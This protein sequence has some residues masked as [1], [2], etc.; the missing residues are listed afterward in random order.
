MD[1]GKQSIKSSIKGGIQPKTFGNTGQNPNM[2]GQLGLEQKPKSRF[3]QPNMTNYAPIPASQKVSIKPV[4]MSQQSNKRNEDVNLATFLVPDGMTKEQYQQQS[5]VVSQ[6]FQIVDLYPVQI[7]DNDIKDEQ[8]TAASQEQEEVTPYQISV[9]HYRAPRQN[10]NIVLSI[11]DSDD[12]N[13]RKEVNYQETEI[14]KFGNAAVNMIYRQKLLYL[15][16]KSIKLEQQQGRV[17]PVALETLP[18]SQDNFKRISIKLC[19]Q[20]QAILQQIKENTSQ[21]DQVVKELSKYSVV[22]QVKQIVIDKSYNKIL[23]RLNVL[24]QIMNQNL[25]KIN[26]LIQLTE[27]QNEKVPAVSM[28]NMIDFIIKLPQQQSI[29]FSQLKY[30]SFYT[31]QIMCKQLEVQEEQCTSCSQFV[32]QFNQGVDAVQILYDFAKLKIPKLYNKLDISNNKLNLIVLPYLEFRQKNDFI[33]Q[34][35]QKYLIKMQEKKYFIMKTLMQEIMTKEEVEQLDQNYI[36]NQYATYRNQI[37]RNPNKFNYEILKKRPLFIL[38]QIK[39]LFHA[40]LQIEDL[41]YKIQNLQ[42]VYDTYVQ[43]PI[44]EQQLR[45]VQLNKMK[46][47]KQTLETDDQEVFRDKVVELKQDMDILFKFQN[48]FPS[49]VEGLPYGFIR[50]KDWID[51]EIGSGLTLLRILNS[52]LHSI[53]ILENQISE[54]EGLQL[55]EKSKKLISQILKLIDQEIPLQYYDSKLKLP[56]EIQNAV[57]EITN[58][59]LLDDETKQT[60]QKTPLQLP[61]ATPN[62]Q[63]NLQEQCSKVLER[64]SKARESILIKKQI[65]QEIST[66]YT[67]LNDY[68]FKYQIW[69]HINATRYLMTS[70]MFYD[71]ISTIISVEPQRFTLDGIIKKIRD[72][73]IYFEMNQNVQTSIYFKVHL[74]DG[75]QLLQ[76]FKDSQDEYS[77][78]LIANSKKPG[79][80][81]IDSLVNSLTNNVNNFLKI[82]TCTLTQQKDAILRA[83]PMYIGMIKEQFEDSSKAAELDQKFSEAETV[84]AETDTFFEKG[85]NKLGKIYELGVEAVGQEKTKKTM[86]LE[87]FRMSLGFDSQIQ[88]LKDKAEV[89]HNQFLMYKEKLS[90]NSLP[91]YKNKLEQKL[92]E[93]ESLNQTILMFDKT[94]TS[95]YYSSID[96]L[97]ALTELQQK[98]ENMLSL[99]NSSFIL[100]GLNKQLKQQQDTYGEVKKIQSGIKLHPSIEPIVLTTQ[101]IQAN[102]IEM[103]SNMIQ[104]ITAFVE[105]YDGFML[106]QDQINLLSEEFFQTVYRWLTFYEGKPS[107]RKLIYIEALAKIDVAIE[108]IGKFPILRVPCTKIYQTLKKVVETYQRDVNTEVMKMLSEFGQTYQTKGNKVQS[109]QEFQNELTYLLT[110]ENSKEATRKALQA[111]FEKNKKAEQPLS[112]MSQFVKATQTI[113][114]DERLKSMKR[115]KKLQNPDEIQTQMGG[116]QMDQWISS[117]KNMTN[118]LDMY[119]KNVNDNQLQPLVN[120]TQKIEDSAKGMSNQDLKKFIGRFL[121]MLKIDY[122]LSKFQ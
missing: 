3:V 33:L 31:C 117:C 4:D 7:K 99:A 34:D 53:D 2:S 52:K 11:K 42:N 6:N 83:M 111:F 29:E 84:L 60:P 64:L 58:K 49:E 91:I 112:R 22:S 119:F 30:A 97:D 113:S 79:S 101:E 61:L 76:L 78:L 46:I 68:C 104:I 39:L 44:L 20:V 37:I 38:Q 35:I 92:K 88:I 116:G 8:D 51:C 114:K 32:I 9:Y 120:Y 82:K 48:M 118:A 1:P 12:R 106:F 41:F 27:I 105:I 71:I 65:I 13:T 59:Y 26:E 18:Q 70:Q 81:S 50:I 10:F 45:Q 21:F 14:G 102:L 94:I 108:K 5:A 109:F 103:L 87:Q 17:L 66:Q 86:S 57:I 73:M 55:I 96:F 122:N 62:A 36:L 107:D 56:T 25:N 100:E 115:L 74:K 54:A 89:A 19:D 72:H 63:I 43:F 95:I 98:I 110:P 75:L 15:P 69:E 77:R 67:S 24:Q 47:Q 121:E 85:E 28:Q 90:L 80:V 16:Q 93:F 40:Q 23:D